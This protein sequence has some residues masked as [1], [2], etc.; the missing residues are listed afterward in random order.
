MRPSPENTK[1]YQDTG[2]LKPR[3]FRTALIVNLCCNTVSFV[4]G[5]LA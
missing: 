1:G 5:S 3:P 4:L 2:G